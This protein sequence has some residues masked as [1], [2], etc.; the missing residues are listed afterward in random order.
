[1]ASRRDNNEAG[2]SLCIILGLA[3]CL[4]GFAALNAIFHF[5]A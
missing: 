1:M 5:A 3:A 2:I 4:F